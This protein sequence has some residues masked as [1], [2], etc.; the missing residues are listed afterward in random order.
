MNTTYQLYEDETKHD[1]TFIPKDHPQKEMLI[2]GKP[3]IWEIEAEN[4]EEACEKRDQYLQMR[5]V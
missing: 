5:A 1:R 2:N 4:F 3:L